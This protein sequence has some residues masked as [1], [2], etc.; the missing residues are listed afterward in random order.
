MWGPLRTLT[1]VGVLNESAQDTREKFKT[2][3]RGGP[4]ESG[5]GGRERFSDHCQLASITGGCPATRS[6]LFQAQAAEIPVIIWV[7]FTLIGVYLPFDPSLEGQL[8]THFKSIC[9][10][11]ML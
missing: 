8:Q 10:L 11:P 6:V 7:D 5:G 4:A 9:Q 3:W 2:A 1:W